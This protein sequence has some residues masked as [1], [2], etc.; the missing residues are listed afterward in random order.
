MPHATHLEAKALSGGKLN[1]AN[2][3][4]AAKSGSDSINTNSRPM[5][6]GVMVKADVNHFAL[7]CSCLLTTARGL[8]K[9]F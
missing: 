1:E 5:K 2:Q 3:G 7:G 8:R 6:L 9:R 4:D